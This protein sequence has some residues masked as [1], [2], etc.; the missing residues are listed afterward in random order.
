VET[1]RIANTFEECWCKGL[2][3]NG[4]ET[5]RKVSSG[6][7]LPMEDGRRHSYVSAEDPV[8]KE[9]LVENRECAQQL[10]DA[11]Q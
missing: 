3:R 8:K 4:V 10:E 2:K 6:G 7:H 1:A 11:L 9:A 5:G